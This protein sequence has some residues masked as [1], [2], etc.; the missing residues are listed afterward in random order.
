MIR[1]AIKTRQK[2]DQNK[3]SISFSSQLCDNNFATVK[4]LD[5]VPEWR[6]DCKLP[7]YYVTSSE[8]PI[9]ESTGHGTKDDCMV[10]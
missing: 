4:L 7:D 5:R 9:T 1:K 3:Y 8:C 10:H 6:R 2:L